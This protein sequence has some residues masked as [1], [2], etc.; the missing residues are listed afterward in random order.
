[1][2]IFTRLQQEI[3]FMRKL[4]KKIKKKLIIKHNTMDATL[5]ADLQAVADKDVII[6]PNGFD[7]TVTP[8]PVPPVA[9][10]VHFTPSV[11]TP[12]AV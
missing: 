2:W 12:P 5:Q 10:T 4:A 9:E 11:P 8:A 7:V 1:M 3:E 6:A